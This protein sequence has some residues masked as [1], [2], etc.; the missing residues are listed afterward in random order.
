M[1]AEEI[2]GKLPGAHAEVT[3]VNKAKELGLQPKSLEVS[4]DICADCRSFLQREGATITG[5]RSAYWS[6]W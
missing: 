1:K 2:Q 4:R 5:P 3:V 6:H